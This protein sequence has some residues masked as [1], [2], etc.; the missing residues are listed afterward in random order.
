M[1]V[2]LWFLGECR[3]TLLEQ[4]GDEQERVLA[5]VAPEVAARTLVE[6][7]LQSVFVHALHEPLVR[8]QQ[9]VFVAACYPVEFRVALCQFGELGIEVGIGWNL[10]HIKMGEVDAG[11]VEA[12][13]IEHVGIVGCNH[14]RVHTTH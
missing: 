1:A 5:P 13:V 4:L 6:C 10:L 12:D 7:V 3:Y 8:W 9:P 11:G 2:S 14:K